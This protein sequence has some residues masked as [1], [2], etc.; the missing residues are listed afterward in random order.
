MLGTPHYMA[1]EIIQG[2]GY[3]KEVDIWA[4]GICMFEFQCGYVPFGED[5]EDPFQIYR[6]IMSA[7][8]EFPTYF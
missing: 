1:P 6:L 5:E 8:Y 7:E 3:S 2:K 4:L